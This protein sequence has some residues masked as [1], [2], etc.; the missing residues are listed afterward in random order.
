MSG[1]ADTDG[2]CLGRCG[3]DEDWVARN[4]VGYYSW[5]SSK[6]SAVE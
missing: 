3:S 4:E 2:F 5:V 6:L 1:A